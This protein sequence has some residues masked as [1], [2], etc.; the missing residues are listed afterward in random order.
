MKPDDV[1]TWQ[2][3]L[4]ALQALVTAPFIIFLIVL[5]TVAITI[6]AY[7]ERSAR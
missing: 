1:V 5:A 7:Q 2:Q 3:R 4:D 6:T